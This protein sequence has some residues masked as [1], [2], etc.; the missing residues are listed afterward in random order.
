M[1]QIKTMLILLILDG[2]GLAKPGAGNAISLA[3]IPT[4][5]KI[6]SMPGATELQASGSSVG[7]PDGYMGNSEVGHLN[8]GAGRVVYQQITAINLAIDEDTLKDNK[9]LLQMFSDVKA[10]GGCLHMLGLLSDAGVHSHINHLKSLICIA[11]NHD[12][13]IILHLFTDGRDSDPEHGLFYIRQL[14]DFLTSKKNIKIGTICGRFYAMDRDKRWERV[15]E[16]WDAIVHGIGI[17]VED[18]ISAVQQ[19]YENGETDEFIKPRIIGSKEDVCVQDSDGLLFFNFRADRARELVAPFFISAFDGFDRGF[20]PKLSSIVTMTDYD[21]T[22]TIPSLFYKE[23]VMHT[24]GEVISDLGMQQLRIAETEKYAHVTYFFSGGQEEPFPGEDRVLVPSPKT[25]KTYD[26]KP[27]MSAIEVT[28]NL[29]DAIESKKYSFIVCNLANSDMVGHTGNIQASIE[30]L[31]VVDKCV[32]CIEASVQKQHACLVV[33]S[34]HG[35][36][37]Q[38]LD[39]SGHKQTAHT[40]N[41]VP[42]AVLF[43]G[44]SLSLTPGGK[45]GD[46]APTILNILGI[47]IPYAMTGNNLLN[48]KVQEGKHE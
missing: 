30:A 39:V 37:E 9:V 17:Q 23:H 47:D 6:F 5:K 40:C 29:I 11:E 33:T 35:N 45:L 18:A 15:K 21:H 4:L 26:L 20:I 43:D 38:M 46:I 3:H 44:K 28:N 25:V 13:T 8:I 16:A 1:H 42:L 24:L 48:I 12:I 7:L 10:A 19:A 32:A 41:P 31:E 2:Y 14:K 36:I 34:D 22:Y 27:E